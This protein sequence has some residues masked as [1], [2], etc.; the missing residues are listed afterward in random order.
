[1]AGD[2]YL[3]IAV[4]GIGYQEKKSAQTSSGA[5]AGQLLAL[6]GSAL[7]DASLL[8]AIAASFTPATESSNFSALIS[9]FYL[10]S[11]SGGNVTCTLP[12]ATTSSGM[13]LIAEVSAASGTN[14]L[15][16]ATVSAQTIN[17][18]SAASLPTLL[19]VSQTYLF[20][21]DGSNWWTV[22]PVTDLANNV[23][24]TVQVPH[25]GTGH[26][27]LTNHSVIVGAGTS[28]VTQVSPSST[29]GLAL[30]SAGSSADPTFGALALGAA[31]AVS[32]VLPI[33]NSSGAVTATAGSTSITA[34]SLIY[35]DSSG[36]IQLAD[37]AAASTAATGFAPVAISASASGTVIIGDGPNVGVSG[38][39]RGTQYLLGT[40]GAVTVTVPTASGSIVQTV[41]FA[42]TTTELQVHIGM[43][44]IRA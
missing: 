34:G 24:G 10:V 44:S 8:P 30:V 5:I 9:H 21:S 39:T 37:N 35:L 19:N 20:I 27:S 4:S 2:T 42:Q 14:A 1:M 31:G 38:L 22:S 41:G 13:Q 29:S 43:F 33:L 3:E 32:G 17:N 15:S 28:A 12:D 7:V 18:A 16:F 36:L 40:A 25:G 6:N 11:L 26:T 23:T